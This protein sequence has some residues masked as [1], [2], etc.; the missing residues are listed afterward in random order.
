MDRLILGTIVI[1]LTIWGCIVL[2]TRPPTEPPKY[3]DEV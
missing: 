1:V 3:D 2:T